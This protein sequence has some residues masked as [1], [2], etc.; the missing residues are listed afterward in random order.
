MRSDSATP[1]PFGEKLGSVDVNK[2]VNEQ[3]ASAAPQIREAV[4]ADYPRIAS[5]E[6]R[7]GLL[8][9]SH[10]EWTHLWIDNPA[11][12]PNWTIGWVVENAAGEIVGYVG[13]V[14]SAF[15]FRRKK[16]IAASGR[17]LVVDEPYRSYSF[18]LF[19]QFFNQP[20]VDLI[21][22]TTVNV[23]AV[24]LHELFHCE[25][26][27]VGVWDRSAFWITHYRGFAAKLAATKNLPLPNL[28]G[29]PISAA[30]AAKDKFRRQP[31]KPSTTGIE[32]TAAT[33]FDPSFDAFWEELRETRADFLLASRS[34]V[35]LDW[36]FKFALEN[37]R[38]W[39]ATVSQGGKLLAYAVFLRQD[40]HQV[41]LKRVRLVD[42]RTLTG[43]PSL[44]APM[45]T[46][47]LRRCREQNIEMLEVIGASPQVQRVLADFAPHYRDL[48]A[49][50]YFYKAKDKQLAASLKDPGVWDPSPFD[51]DGAL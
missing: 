48:P 21:V 44:L 35:I 45:L 13:N 12:P 15:E 7:Y 11:C 32:A 2:S 27:P 51:G 36:H 10:E 6:S 42:F 19:S 1:F 23:N 39:V 31:R 8:P 46:G 41:G 20:N 9:K 14:P 5:L 4:F 25:R 40:N 18:P 16:L 49:W 24:K 47:A 33:T 43:N 30:L 28:L 37:N 34:R 17:G 26:A 38:A 3:P 29:Y 50:L 22:N